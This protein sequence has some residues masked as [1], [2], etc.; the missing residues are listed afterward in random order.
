MVMTG[1]NVSMDVDEE[2]YAGDG[3]ETFEAREASDGDRRGSWQFL[4]R[5]TN[6]TC[7]ANSRTFDAEPLTD[8]ARMLH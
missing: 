2:V 8:A 3:D 6:I 1:E 4:E 5:D 7:L